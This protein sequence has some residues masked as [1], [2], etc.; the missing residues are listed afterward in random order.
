MNIAEKS[1]PQ[2]PRLGF[3]GKIQGML[4]DH[5]TTMV[6]AKIVVVRLPLELKLKLLDRQ[7]ENILVDRIV[8]C[9]C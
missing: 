7:I 2:N 6:L 1:K 5:K 8:D 4:A 9:H 3:Y